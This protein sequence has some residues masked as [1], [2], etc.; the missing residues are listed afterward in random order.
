M[1]PASSFLSRTSPR[2]AA[3]T[4]AIVVIAV[5]TA[6]PLMASRTIAVLVTGA[7]AVMYVAYFLITSVLLVARV[8]GWPSKP[9][10]FALG[11][12]GLSL[13]VLAVVFTAAMMVNLMW[14]RAA[15]N[16]HKFGLPVAWWLSGIP[17]V[18]GLGY[19]LVRV[20]PKLRRQGSESRL[21]VDARSAGA[22]D[23]VL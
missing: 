22:G 3:P 13:T 10:P 9:A 12:W 16:P 7:V 6:L 21:A 8:K 19:Y 11:R 14:P 5:M 2:T 17:L 18:V 1:L 4:G 15:T 23:R 20:A